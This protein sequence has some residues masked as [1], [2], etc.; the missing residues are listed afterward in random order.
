[1]S[2]RR[3]LGPGPEHAARVAA[4]EAD[5]HDAIPGNRFPALDELRGRG[6]FSP[7]PAPAPSARRTLGVGA[8]ATSGTDSTD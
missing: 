4:A 2:E 3:T 1:M 7:H 8:R 5:L 6:V